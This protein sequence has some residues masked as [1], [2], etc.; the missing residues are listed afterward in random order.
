[1]NSPLRLSA[2]SRVGGRGMICRW[3]EAVGGGATMNFHSPF[4]IGVIA[5]AD[6]E[7]NWTGPAWRAVG[8]PLPL[9]GAAPEPLP[10]GSSAA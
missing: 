1:M 3:D 5:L 10:P 2:K 9:A 7:L 6:D 8:L 4:P